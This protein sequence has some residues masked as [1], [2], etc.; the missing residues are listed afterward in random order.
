[1]KQIHIYIYIYIYIYINIYIYSL[2]SIIR[3]LWDWWKCWQIREGEIKHEIEWK[4]KFCK[5][6]S[7]VVKWGWRNIRGQIIEENCIYIYIYIY[8]YTHTHIYIYIYIYIFKNV[9]LA[10]GSGCVMDCHWRPGVRFPVLK[11]NFTSFARD[12]KWGTI[13]KWPRCRWDVKH[14]QPTINVNHSV[15]CDS[16][17]ITNKN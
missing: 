6:K 13:S 14:N 11:L 3:H 16:C 10:W 1:M 9:N 5:S 17:I 12:S 4:L 7:I 2:P 8:I 15:L